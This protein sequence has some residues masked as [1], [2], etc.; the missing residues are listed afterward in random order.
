MESIK[1]VRSPEG[2]YSL[3]IENKTKQTIPESVRGRV[4]S[5]QEFPVVPAHVAQ[6]LSIDP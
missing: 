1:E 3:K 6:L 4:T 2:W 5:N